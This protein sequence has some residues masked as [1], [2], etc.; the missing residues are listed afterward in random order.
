MDARRFGRTARLVALAAVG[1]VTCL[2]LVPVAINAAT[3]GSA[4][5][6]LG[7]H[8]RWLWPALIGLS[9]LTACL[10]AWDRLSALLVRRRP[11]HPANRRVAL[12][13]V[14]RFVRA[15]VDGSPAEQ[16][17]LK[18]GVV[19]RV[20]P[21]LSTRV[22]H[23]VV[24][25]GEAGAGKTTLLL[26]LAE[27]LLARAALDPVQPVPALVDLGGW[28]RDDDFGEWLL[29][30]LADRYRIAPR[31]GRAWLRERN[32][33]LLFD[34]LDDLAPADRVE[35]LAWITALNVPQVVL[36]TASD[37][38][39]H[40]PRC[41]VVQVEPLSRTVVQEL[42]AA[43]GPRLDGLHDELEKNPD[44]WDELRTP[45]AFG[46]LALAYRAGRAEYRGVLDTYVV[47]SAARGATR[48]ERTVRALR[49]LARIARRKRDLLA[50]SRLP[51]RHVWLDFVGP[52]VVWR[53]FRRAA[54]GALAGAAAALCFVV[55][56]RLGLVAAAVAAVATVLVPHSAFRVTRRD[57]RRGN[58]WAATGFAAGAVTTGGVAA[59][60]GVLG[61]Q[62]ARWPAAVGYGLVVVV[63]LLVAY[64]NTRD[65]YWAVACALVPAGAMVVTGPSAE[66]LAGLGIGLGTGAVAGAFVGGLREV[67]SGVRVRPATG[68]RWLPAAGAVG[69]GLAA[70][71]GADV[72]PSAWG[73]ATGLLVGLVVTPIATRPFH[74]VAEL[75]A[76]PLALDE[77]PLRR[78][79]ILQ[80][81][82]D[83]VLLV[84]GHRF[85]HEVVRDHLA[86]CDPAELATSVE[87]RRAELS[88]TGSGPTA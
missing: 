47:E 81:A 52:D 34:G 41:D 71:A 20:G 16:L 77:F 59:L 5:P 65:R 53:L 22:R 82:R 11:A 58:L 80:S 37:E 18:L 30:V 28:R 21:R 61:A 68:L 55:G 62:V 44:L 57:P 45:L 74:P 26:E 60:G 25:A 46:L 84:D 48:P 86:E 6:V 7:P 56:V 63:A 39:E 24:V 9:A 38:H 76:R 3:G 88:P 83:R 1:G 79:A 78:K 27:A 8:A 51:A 85:P 54:P 23:P 70:L 17:R 72:R 42:I 43:C 15:R 2:V 50:R 69:V 19:P 14:E 29:R 40:L 33:V 49:F 12:E 36:C 66:L 31:V 73:A 4:L 87:R 75:L 35:C 10:A 64:G 13:R 32:L 67:W